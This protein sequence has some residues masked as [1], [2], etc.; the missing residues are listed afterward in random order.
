MAAYEGH[1]TPNS[2]PFR[3]KLAA[4]K[5]WGMVAT[6]ADTVTLTDVG[7]NV[8]LPSSPETLLD[9]LLQAFQ[10][11][12]IFWTVYTEAAKG[13]P[14][15]PSSVGNVAVTAHGV[16][17]RARDVFTRSFIDSAIA[18]G[19]AERLPG[20][21]VKLL[22]IGEPSSTPAIRTTDTEPTPKT[23][24]LTVADSQAPG[25][26]QVWSDDGVEVVFTVT[27]NKP[28]SATAFMQVGAVVT[29]IEALRDVLT[30]E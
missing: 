9:T 28:L 26:H 5:D 15:Y 25:I 20:G 3:Q 29:A 6:T 17:V 22:A 8:A 19:L 11:C 1:T 27:S 23:P 2:G 30:E 10:A 24:P 12:P 21:E 18:V 4:L 14:L 16:S 7:M 13:V